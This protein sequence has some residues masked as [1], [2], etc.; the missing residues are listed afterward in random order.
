MR[1][2]ISFC[3]IAALITI[4]PFLGCRSTRADQQDSTVQTSLWQPLPLLVDGL[5]DDWVKPLPYFESR[6]KLAWAISNDKENVYIMLSSKDRMEQQKILQ[7][8]LTVWL[9]A[10]AD[11][12]EATSVGIAFPMD[13]RNDRDRALMEQAQ[14]DKYKNKGVSPDDLKGYSLIGFNKD[15]PIENFDDGQANKEGIVT[16]IAYNTTG[17]LIY[18]ASVPLNAIF[19]NYNFSSYSRRRF[20]VGFFI[21]GIPPQPGMRGGGGGGVS[22]GGGV[23]MGTFGSGGGLGLSI[24]TGS[25]GRIGGG[26]KQLTKQSKIWMVTSLAK[27]ATN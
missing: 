8:G 7:G 5:D 27:P 19:P 26:N 11:K 1:V 17:D 21:E 12:D 2:P 13:G 9:N 20:A 23:G 25:L 24:G 3:G 10:K 4:V 16:K 6:E 18:E 15:E 14:P 22:I